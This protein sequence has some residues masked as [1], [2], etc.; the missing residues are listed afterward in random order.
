M[1]KL[2][3]SIVEDR[4]HVY[5]PSYSVKF[6]SSWGL[7]HPLMLTVA[8]VIYSSLGRDLAR[9]RQ[10]SARQL[11]FRNTYTLYNNLEYR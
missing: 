6:D 1:C 9:N 7:M 2:L 11:I 4:R 10:K 5:V 3:M 8:L